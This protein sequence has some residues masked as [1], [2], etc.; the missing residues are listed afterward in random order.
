MRQRAQR[1]NAAPLFVAAAI[2][3]TANAAL[4]TAV[5]TRAVD[6]S[7]FRWVHH[8]LYIAT[9]AT[10]AAAAAG[11]LFWARPRGASRRA[12]LLLAPAAAPLAAIPYLGTHSRRHPLVA[13]AAA[14]F[15]LAG[16]VCSLLPSDRK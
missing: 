3:Y 4:G 12:A 16:L 14:P 10:T 13:L 15:L 8:A 2:A 6:T 7:E 5:A 1:S 9:C 11:G